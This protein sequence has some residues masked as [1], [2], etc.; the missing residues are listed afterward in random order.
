MVAMVAGVFAMPAVVVAMLAIAMLPVAFS[1]REQEVFP[2]IVSDLQ[3]NC[4]AHVARVA[5]MNPG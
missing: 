1:T 3:P 2:H 4:L 5:V